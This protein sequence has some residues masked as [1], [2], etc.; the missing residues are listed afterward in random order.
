VNS[1]ANNSADR[2]AH[3]LRALA[4]LAG[5]NVTLYRAILGTFMESRERF[6]FQLRLP[7]IVDALRSE[8]F[9]ESVDEKEFE[10]AVVQLCE[11]GILDPLPDISDVR[12]VEEFYSPRHVYRLTAKGEAAEKACADFSSTSSPS[13]L[14]TGGLADIRE[15]LM[16]M[17][18]LMDGPP[19]NAGRMRRKLQTLDVLLE[20]FS[21]TAQEFIESLDQPSRRDQVKAGRLIEFCRQWISE[22][23]AE[24]DRIGTI[25]REIEA[26]GSIDSPYWERCRSW[27]LAKPP[28]S[29]AHEDLCERSR[30]AMPMLL[31]GF[32]A[33][34]D[35][36]IHRIDRAHDFRVLAGWF[37]TAESDAEAH[38]LWRTAFG[39]RPARHLSINEATLDE[40]E[41]RHV[42]PN[43]SWLDA[44]PLRLSENISDRRGSWFTGGLSRIIDR[45]SEKE[46]LAAAAHEESRR[47]LETQHRLGS[48]DRI[49]LSQL[50]N[51]EANEF[52]LFLDLLGEAA[53]KVFASES[54]EILS[55]DGRLR[56]RL[57]PVTDG[58]TALIRTSEGMLSGPD[59]WIHIEPT[60][61]HETSEAR[62]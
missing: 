32:A 13:E 37:A 5:E 43:T 23:E 49:R 60:S 41:A 56:V 50:E 11:W 24:S 8:N 62:A 53:A 7:E 26:A 36:G 34:H 6:V 16:E 1:L 22:L 20:D 17:R 29:S 30:A 15:F 38:V 61:L 59:H 2:S 51:L 31:R 45:S 58:R 42:L 55:G 57:E 46:K 10:S 9:S 44:P 52:E 39:L 21:H 33:D 12:I 14:Q 40:R 3:P 35:R 47:L 19:M 27:F 4:G 28:Q 18:Q 48:G 54:Q 25:V